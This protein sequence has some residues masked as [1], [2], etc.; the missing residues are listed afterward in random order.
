M[1]LIYAVEIY[2]SEVFQ[3][4]LSGCRFIRIFAFLQSIDYSGLVMNK[5]IFLKIILA[6][7][8]I[9]CVL[10]PVLW[11]CTTGTKNN[12][13]KAGKDSL[14]FKFSYPTL[15]VLLTDTIEQKSYLSLHFWDSLNFADVALQKSPL[16]LE[17]YFVEFSGL[18]QQIPL[19]AAKKS[20]NNMFSKLKTNDSVFNLFVTFSEKYLY[21]PGS[22][23]RNDELY[24]PVLEE[25]L[26][27]KVKTE[28][29]KTRYRFQLKMLLKN[30]IGTKANNIEITTADNSMITMHKVKADYCLLF[31]FTPGCHS[32]ETVVNQLK[33]DSLLSEMVQA[34]RIKV[35]AIATENT[36]DACKSYAGIFPDKWLCGYNK[37]GDI[38]RNYDL[39][40]SPTIYLL[41]RNKKVAL[42][43]TE[44]GAIR[45]FFSTK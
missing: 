34:D 15:P 40:A 14:A 3:L 31:F 25:L 33:S 27:S 8:L 11:G 37:T 4:S 39:K 32:C 17:P 20:I 38:Q 9:L 23:L 19:P 30:R 18:L 10:F 24:L 26:A 36:A 28:T 43:D 35:I 16:V 6:A 41:D 5:R 21:E 7:S 22:P 2:F 44:P 13:N 1:I 45:V 12:A 29:E 42:K